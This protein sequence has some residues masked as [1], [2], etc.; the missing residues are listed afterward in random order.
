MSSTRAERKSPDRA[1]VDD[2]TLQA[3]QRIADAPDDPR[4]IIRATGMS[5]GE[6]M[7]FV[8]SFRDQLPGNL[9]VAV[10]SAV[11]ELRATTA[12]YL[13]PASRPRT[14]AEFIASVAA[15]AQV[16][17]ELVVRVLEAVARVIAADLSSGGPGVLVL[18]GLAQ[19][20]VRRIPA[21]KARKGINPFTK[22]EVVF[23]ARPARSVVKCRPLKS[24]RSMVSE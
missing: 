5:P 22:Q 21:S 19:V 15:V 20:M 13:R 14:R 3:M 18:P 23:K 2:D 10:D 24:L 16:P 4:A 9:R 8:A 17:T 1:W 6:F 7:A 12:E 11:A